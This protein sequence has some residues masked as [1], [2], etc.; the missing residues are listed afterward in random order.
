[1]QLSHLKSVVDN[2]RTDLKVVVP[3][4][5]CSLKVTG[6]LKKKCPSSNSRNFVYFVRDYAWPSELKKKIPH[7][8]N[9]HVSLETTALEG[10]L[11]I[12]MQV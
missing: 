5:N 8:S 7:D 1:M 3:K 6:K 12:I 11:Y 4:L 9:G 2:S 10:E